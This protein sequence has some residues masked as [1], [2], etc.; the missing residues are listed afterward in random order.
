VCLP[1]KVHVLLGLSSGSHQKV[2]TELQHQG[3][4]EMLVDTSADIAPSNGDMEWKTLPT[5]LKDDES[6]VHTVQDICN[7]P[8]VLFKMIYFSSVREVKGMQKDWIQ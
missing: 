7:S 2:V 5:P 6:F 4:E 8:L 3:S 1:S